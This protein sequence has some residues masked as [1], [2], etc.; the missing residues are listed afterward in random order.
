MHS[1]RRKAAGVPLCD[2]SHAHL[3]R[4]EQLLLLSPGGLQL[5]LD[6]QQGVTQLQTKWQAGGTSA[7]QRRAVRGLAGGERQVVPPQPG[8]LQPEQAIGYASQSC[9]EQGCTHALTSTTASASG[10]GKPARS[11]SSARCCSRAARVNMPSVIEQRSACCCSRS[12][13]NCY[14]TCTS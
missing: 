6:L 7:G 2:Q 10:A 3:S 14:P 5:L 4:R 13:H 9:A 1:C 12:S 11:C 8:C